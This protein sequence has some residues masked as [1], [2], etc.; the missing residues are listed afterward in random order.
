MCGKF[1]A[2]ASWHRVVSFSRAMTDIAEGQEKE[3]V[4]YRPMTVLP[5]IIWDANMQRRRILPMRWGYPA[6]NNYLTPKHI[7]VRAETIDTTPSFAPQFHAGRRGI[8]MMKTFNEGIELPNGKTEQWT[9]NP[10]DGV[11]RGFAFLFQGYEMQGQRDPLLCCAMVTVPANTLIA[12][13][14]DRMPAILEEQ[15]WETWLGEVATPPAVVKS[16]LKTMEAVNWRMDR[17]AKSSRSAT[18][19]NQQ[20][21]F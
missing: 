13:I 8:V 6:L 20:E 19:T 12:P 16:V 5:V 11:S 15:D 4:V 3:T 14:T 10:D 1:T 7:H 9:V 17:E 2:M 18:P 21:L